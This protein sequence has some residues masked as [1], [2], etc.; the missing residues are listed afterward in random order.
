MDEQLG[1]L[2]NE[3]KME[4]KQ[5]DLHLEEGSSSYSVS[6][7][8]SGTEEDE[9]DTEGR[10]EKAAVEAE[11]KKRASEGKVW[12]SILPGHNFKFLH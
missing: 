7:P 1:E 3:L 9:T 8:S 11:N 5:T 4:G 6:L 2:Y 10:K 12:K